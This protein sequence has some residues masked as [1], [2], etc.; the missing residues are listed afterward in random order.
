MSCESFLW[1]ASLNVHFIPA[2]ATDFIEVYEKEKYY[3]RG[4]LPNE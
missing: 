1:A 4:K 2:N 3:I